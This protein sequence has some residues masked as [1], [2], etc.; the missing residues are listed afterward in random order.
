MQTNH[1]TNLYSGGSDRWSQ[2]ANLVLASAYPALWTLLGPEVERWVRAPSFLGR[3]SDDDDLQ[4]EIV[5]RTWVKLHERDHARLRAFATEELAVARDAARRARAWFWRVVK[6]VGIDMLR[7]VPEFVRE[8]NAWRTHVEIAEDIAADN[9]V[10]ARFAV[11]ELLAYLDARGRPAYR[12]ALVLWSQG[13]DARDTARALG[14]RD[15]GDANR[16]VDA[17]KELLRR[18]F[19]EAA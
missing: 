17:A 11:R 15:A 9:D 3:V 18:H 4:R 5:V 1:A 7:G 19:R 13:F 14:L 12:E 10:D 2:I 16:M 6:N 8:D